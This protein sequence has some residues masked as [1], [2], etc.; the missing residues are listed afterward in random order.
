MK[1]AVLDG[2]PIDLLPPESIRECILQWLIQPESSYQVITLNALMM[3]A[4]RNS[5]ALKRA[6]AEAALV[7]IDG[8]GIS[9]AL[10]RR[11]VVPTPRYRGIDLTRY[12]LE[13]A[14]LLQKSV[15]FYGA[16]RLV[17]ARLRKVIVEKWPGIKILGMR[18]G[19]EEGDVRPDIVVKK[20]DILLVAL[21]TPRQEL[22]LA[23]VLKDLPGTVGMGVGGSFDVLAGIKPEAPPF[24]QKIGVEW[25]FRMV[26][27]PGRCRKLPELAQFWV[28]YVLLSGKEKSDG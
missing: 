19:Y 26:Q 21:G 15:Y 28:R 7:I 11:G 14:S 27:E 23:T 6:I 25:L 24:L 9:I 13:Q 5:P 3:M 4:A 18:D 20:P 22:F 8:A 10:K 2:M 16:S 1:R 17:L 12:L